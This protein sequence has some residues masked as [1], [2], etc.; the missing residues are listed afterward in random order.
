MTNHYNVLPIR[1]KSTKEIAEAFRV[2]RNMVFK[3]KKE[4]API[5]RVGRGLQAD[6]YELS[7]W[8]NERG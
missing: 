8:L 4:K 6:Y 3:W 5:V 1:L 2:S 7:K